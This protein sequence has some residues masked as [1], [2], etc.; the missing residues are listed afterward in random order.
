MK[1]ILGVSLILLL[2]VESFG[3]LVTRKDYDAAFAIQAGGELSFLVPFKSPK[4]GIS[5]T[6]G[7]KMTFPFTRKWFMGSE[8][9]YSVFKCGNKL[10]SSS[11]ENVNADFNLKRIQMPIYLKY[12][13]N[14]NKASI[15]FGVYA[16]RVFDDKSAFAAENPFSAEVN[17]WDAGITLGYEQRIV[18]HLNLMVRLS[19]GGMS[20]LKKNTYTNESLYPLQGSLTLSYDF[21]RIGDCG[22]D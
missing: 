2:G 17:P 13:L 3:Q 19:G 11:A 5:P 4:P 14:S 15:L 7:L 22:C 10:T 1:V 6:I 16:S 21:L 12:M 8:I 9:N 20:L 18:K